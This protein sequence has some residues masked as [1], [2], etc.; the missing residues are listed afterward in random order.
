VLHCGLFALASVSRIV[1]KVGVVL[2][3]QPQEIGNIGVHLPARNPGDSPYRCLSYDV[4]KKTVFPDLLYEH[5][6]KNARSG[7]PRAVSDT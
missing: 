2:I 4:P 7:I 6:E 5:P 1:N 3:H